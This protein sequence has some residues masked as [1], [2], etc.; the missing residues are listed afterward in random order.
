M[1]AVGFALGDVTLGDFLETH[2][3]TLKTGSETP[4]LYLGTPSPRDIPAAQAFADTLRAQDCRVFV[5]LTDRALGDQI[6]DAV[7]RGI[8]FF[9]AYGANEIANN[10]ARVKILTTSE[11]VGLPVSELPSY[12]QS[13]FR[14]SVSSV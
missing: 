13:S 10:T 9:V 2:S 5:N 1:P 7:K 6:K 3:L 14:P 12:V 8:P 11:E 4:Q